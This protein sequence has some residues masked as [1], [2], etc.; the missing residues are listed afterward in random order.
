MTSEP[1]ADRLTMADIKIA[2]GPGAKLLPAAAATQG[3]AERT[4][5]AS[6]GQPKISRKRRNGA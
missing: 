1:G 6:D 2:P 3:E 5:P 4:A